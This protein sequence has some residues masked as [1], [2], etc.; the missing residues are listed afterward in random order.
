VLS[1]LTCDITGLSDFSDIGV[2]APYRKQVQKIRE[3]LKRNQLD[4]I[5]VGSVEEFQG[6]EARVII[7]STVRSHNQY[8]ESDVKHGLGFVASPKRFNV[9]ITRAQALLIV[10]GNPHV[11]LTDPHWAALLSYIQSRGGCCGPEK[12]GA[13]DDLSIALA[14]VQFQSGSADYTDDDDEDGSA[15]GAEV[16]F[17][18]PD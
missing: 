12:I 11:L 6:R 16:A 5:V 4:K 1:M 14:N 8:V 13:V 17:V 7:I 18:I 10:I 3:A 2:I 15:R 9:A